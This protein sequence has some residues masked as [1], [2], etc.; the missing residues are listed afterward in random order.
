MKEK[1]D[2]L[3][4]A[5]CP[6]CGDRIILPTVAIR[7]VYGGDKSPQDPHVWCADNGH[8]IGYLSECTTLKPITNPSA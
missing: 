5:R 8:W 7:K 6:E 1:A 3:D 4:A 2:G